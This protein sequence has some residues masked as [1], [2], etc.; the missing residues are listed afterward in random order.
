MTGDR[1]KSNSSTLFTYHSDILL[2]T[3][4][5]EA[6]ALSFLCI[7]NSS[8]WILPQYT[9]LTHKLFLNHTSNKAHPFTKHECRRCLVCSI[10][11]LAI[12]IKNNIIYLNTNIR[13]SPRRQYKRYSKTLMLAILLSKSDFIRR[14]IIGKQF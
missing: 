4:R 5:A 3:H 8:R 7:R 13:P 9:T 2:S 6:L 14:T 12:Y 10:I 1:K 11:Y